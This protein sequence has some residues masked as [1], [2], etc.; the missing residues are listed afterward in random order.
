MNRKRR[1]E[2][3][4][5][6]KD[7]AFNG[8]WYRPHKLRKIKYTKDDIEL[9]RQARDAADEAG[10]KR[11]VARGLWQY[12]YPDELTEEQAKEWLASGRRLGERPKE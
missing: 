8:Y 10:R 2:M 4:Q 3:D 11:M 9:L 1:K 5:F 6:F 12:A 7:H